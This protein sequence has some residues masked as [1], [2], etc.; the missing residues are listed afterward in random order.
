M[1]KHNAIILTF[2][3]QMHF[4][5]H[6]NLLKNMA[7]FTYWILVIGPI[8]IQYRVID[9]SQHISV[10]K[11]RTN[12]HAWDLWKLAWS[13]KELHLLGLPDTWNFS[14]TALLS[15]FQSSQGALKST[16]YSTY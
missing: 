3:Y 8:A 15:G 13:C 11:I 5:S 4:S 1:I 9:A 2:T 6:W 14:G 12:C 10:L 16:E 7:E